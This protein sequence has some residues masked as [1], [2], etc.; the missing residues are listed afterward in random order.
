MMRVA[1][2]VALALASALYSS[3]AA[4]QTFTR[5]DVPRGEVTGLD[6][7]IE[8]N[9]R[10]VP[11][12]RVRWFVTVYEIVKGRELRP[13]A[14]TELR[15]LVSFAR[16][17]PVATAVTDAR[18]RASLSFAI[19]EGLFGSFNLVVEARS[20]R[21]VKRD[22]DV[23]IDLHNRYRTELFVDR[24]EVP[25]G[26]AV[27]VWGR[28]HDLARH[29]PASEHEVRVSAEVDGRLIG[30]E[31]G[32]S[33]DERGLFRARLV[34]PDESA[35]LRV[36]ARAKGAG[37]VVARVGVK[38][39]EVPDL[40]VYARPDRAVVSP[41]ETV[42]V[43]V[44]VRTADGRPVARARLSGLSIPEPEEPDALAQ[45]EGKNDGKN[46]GKKKIKPVYT[47][48]KGR[49]RVPWEVRSSD[50]IA[51]VSGQI[52]ALREGFGVGSGTVTVRAA[53]VPLTASFA[54]E[55]GALIPGLPGR[56]FVQAFHPDG[57][58]WAGLSARL[59]GGRISA[60]ATTTDEDGVA[61][62]E[63]TVQNGNTGAPSACTGPT[64]AATRVSLG[65]HDKELCL[66]V[67]PD[68]TVRV[69]SRP[70]VLAGADLQ[71][72]LFAARAVASAPISVTVLSRL[73]GTSWAPVTRALVPGKR[74]RV[75]LAIPADATG[76]LWI[77]ARPL[78]GGQ[79]QE[80]RGGTTTV[81]SAP[82]EEFAVKVAAAAK[83][84]TNVT[85]DIGLSRD[86]FG[87]ANGG[88]VGGTGALTFAMAL[89]VGRANKLFAE[90]RKAGGQ[91]PPTGASDGHWQGFLAARTAVD[92]AVSAVL[93]A[94][95][96]VPLAMPAD[97][98]AVGV[99]RDPWRS[100]ARFVRGR[101]GRLLFA[102][103]SHV[104]ENLPDEIDNVAVRGARG[105]RFNSELLT[106]LT[107]QLGVQAVAG[108]DGSPL[109]IEALQALDKHFVYDNVARRLTR[110]R[111]LRLLV[112]LRQFV[113]HEKLDYEWARRG[114][115]RTWLGA[116]RESEDWDDSGVDLEREQFFDGWGRPFAIRKARGARARFRFLEPI[117]GYELL[118]AGPDGK[119][120]TG[121]DVF[122]PFA[123]VLPRGSL[124][125][126]AVGEEALLARLQGVELG[127]ATIAALGEA[128][129][130]GEDSWEISES[131]A[132]RQSWERPQPVADTRDALAI[133]T[134]GPALATPVGFRSLTGSA[135]TGTRVDLTMPWE[136]R[137]YT[138]L[139][140]A[141][142]QNGGA[143]FA[144]RSLSAG[145]P[146]L[147]DVTFPPRL[148]PD[149][150][151]L[152]PVHLI[153]IGKPSEMT[154]RAQGE[155]PVQVEVVG[156]ARFSLAP[157]KA[158]TVQLRITGRR[159]GKGRIKLA[160]AGADGA[161]VRELT[162]HLS[163]MW[164]GSLRAQHA[165]ALVE[166]RATLKVQ[167]PADA[168]PV[169]SFVVVSAARD[170]LRDHGFH[171]ARNRYPALF[172]WAGILRGESLSEVL[173]AQLAGR[174]PTEARPAR[175]R[176]SRRKSSRKKSGKNREDDRADDGG[177]VATMDTL[178]DACAAVAWSAA[179]SDAAADRNSD[180]SGV[181]RRQARRA[182]A[183]LRSASAPSSLHERSALL[184]A[185]AGNA[186]TLGGPDSS[187][188]ANDDPIVELVAKLRRDGWHAPRTERNRPTV[189]A[190]LAAGLLLAD[191]RDVPGRE[192]FKLAR[193]A[194]VPGIR[195][196]KMLRGHKGRAVD[197]WIGTVA[198]AIAARQI[199]EDALAR[200]LVR[201]FSPRLYLAMESGPEP[202]FWLLAA[203]VYGVFGIAEPD[204]DKD[205]IEVA[206]GAGKPRRIR[207][208]HGVATVPIPAGSERVTVTSQ[209]P[210]MARLEA[211][212]VRPVKRASDAPLR[213]KIVG[214]VGY[215]DDVAALEATLINTGG[216]TIWRPVVEIVLPSAA[217]LSGS[218]RASMA[219]A[220]GVVRVDRPDAMGVLRIH[221][222]PLRSQRE[223]RLPVPVRWIGTGR[224]SGFAISTYDADRPWRISSVPARSL[225]I[226]PRPVETWK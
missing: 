169:R 96:R 88:Q 176:R 49:A 37:Q 19:P 125:G 147:I 62:F 14:G 190:R 128:F 51:D 113:H 94:G 188:G 98:V 151:L 194:L 139:A 5:R 129:S 4:S 64:V 111:L 7:A 20:P 24:A 226:A 184:V 12:G 33:T 225:T 25:H 146:L 100:N 112:A 41:G 197:G 222:A 180:P 68:A 43:D 115:P 150:P 89:P 26:A 80:V 103:E 99:L 123:R 18:G 59:Q 209:V 163:V 93:R 40:M 46:D 196:G 74:D 216:Q 172:G 131:K 75:T 110:E 142:D 159:V 87:A 145:A 201:G 164:D 223:V 181:R 121:D 217:A 122:D 214:D 31:H 202:A 38:R 191:A 58:P 153:G 84:T 171:D 219:S 117:V 105:W 198:L 76:P 135:S 221:L 78:I 17:A 42:Q 167:P 1:M 90:L 106:I 136:P 134:V 97:A 161:V 32:L 185:L 138:V 126:E 36:K 200:E 213:A 56:V 195:G 28:V 137:R 83:G 187:S 54:V 61:V 178:I 165:S 144:T 66:P 108:L 114:D 149:E 107:K 91:R 155:G 160:V 143:A 70:R 29:R 168:R 206:V 21:K 119:F 215:A 154:L 65:S 53:R 44:A 11:G 170:L 127:R 39:D 175:K 23:S 212:Y 9:L 10:A 132:N 116:L 35:T 156:A 140:G 189:M 86:L 183:R 166:S 79:Q 204:P 77:R 124:Y 205:V 157:E 16:S 102:L 95:A 224:I 162:R 193:A 57:R 208:D 48:A 67:D 55:G 120:G 92:N 30:R 192:L 27:Q 104:A 3:P 15:A 34:A 118:S 60:P 72:Q 47:D 210:V 8:G 50:D 2:S 141:Y 203:S 45:S 133:Q 179:A 81:W 82:G 130:V 152:V 6:M 63:A 207:L 71:V 218:A 73:R 220:A 174:V 22:F 186:T 177:A 85:V 69:R 13:A 158:H 182:I 109:T 211:R 52:S 199:G 148:R 173:V 101:L